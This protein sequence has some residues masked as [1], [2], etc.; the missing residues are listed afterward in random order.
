MMRIAK[1]LGLREFVVAFLLMAFAASLPNFVLGLTS[2]ARGVPEI[3]FGDVVGGNVVDL[4]FSIALVVLISRRALPATAP[5]LQLSALWTSI[6]AVLPLLLILDGNL[7][8][9]DGIILI[10]AFVF[11]MVW[12]FSKEER[13]KKPYD[14]MVRPSIWRLRR[15][16][17]NVFFGIIFLLLG[18]QGVVSSAASISSDFKIPLSAISILIIGLGNSLPEIY[19]GIVSARR[20]E[21]E[22]ILGDLMG[23][24]IM[25]ATWI[26]GVVVL[27]QPIRIS[28]FSPFAVAR[29]FLIL[30]AAV[31]YFAARSG[32]K[33]TK[34]EA[35]QLFLIYLTFVLIEIFTK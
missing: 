17:I 3:S 20:G 16:I 19:F 35:V 9:I 25:P 32:R 29:I 10:L 18:A 12:L 5:T 34:T 24:V 14:G 31:S 22:M 13:F 1:Y 11:Y 4:T 2:A 30:A 23:S 8:R 27:I 28:D 33:I 21:S 6:I 7:D 15:D 26:L